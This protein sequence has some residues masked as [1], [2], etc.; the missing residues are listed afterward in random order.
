MGPA[1]P[2]Y[3]RTQIAREGIHITFPSLEANTNEINK[4]TSPPPEPSPPEGEGMKNLEYTPSPS[5]L[6]PGERVKPLKFKKKFPP[7]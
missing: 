6:P 2:L 7:P 4:V 5:P 3:L 1:G